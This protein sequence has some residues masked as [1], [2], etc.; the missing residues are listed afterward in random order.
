M[1]AEIENNN[2]CTIDKRKSPKY[3]L[4]I[5]RLTPGDTN[6]IDIFGAINEMSDYVRLHPCYK[7]GH[8]QFVSRGK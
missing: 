7:V 1:P 4:T 2:F 8:A 6:R 3:I 5:I